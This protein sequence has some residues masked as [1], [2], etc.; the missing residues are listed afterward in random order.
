MCKAMCL[1]C[2]VLVLPPAAFA[3]PILASPESVTAAE[4][5]VAILPEPAA[6]VLTGLGLTALAWRARRRRAQ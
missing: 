6:L 2:F 5:P 3:L 4:R 1:V